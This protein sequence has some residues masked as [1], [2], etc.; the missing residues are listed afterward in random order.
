MKGMIQMPVSNIG[1][2]KTLA[3]KRVSFSLPK[4]QTYAVMQSEFDKFGATLIQLAHG[5]WAAAIDGQIRSKFLL[6]NSKNW[7]NDPKASSLVG[8]YDFRSW[9]VV[10]AEDLNADVDYYVM[11]V[12]QRQPEKLDMIVLT[13]SELQKLYDDPR[14]KVGKRGE[15]FFY[16]SRLLNGRLG[17]SRFSKSTSEDYAGWIDI[18]KSKLN[19]YKLLVEQK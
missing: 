16:F 1:K 2:K 6:K 17:D 5:V 9:T 19:N 7:V 3:K 13:K 12:S 14:R 10:S 4:R 11:A 18:D 15:K 8:R